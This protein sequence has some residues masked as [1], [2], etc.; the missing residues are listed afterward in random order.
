MKHMIELVHTGIKNFNNY[1]LYFQEDEENMSM[2][3]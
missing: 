3:R 2:L 1:V